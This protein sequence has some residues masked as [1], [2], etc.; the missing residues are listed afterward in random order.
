MLEVI[1]AL[2]VEFA[3][4]LA[5]NKPNAR[6]THSGPSA[7]WY[8]L[9][10]S[11]MR[12]LRVKV[13]GQLGQLKGLIPVC[14]K[15]CATSLSLCANLEPQIRH[16]NPEGDSVGTGSSST[17]PQIWQ[18]FP[19]TVTRNNS[20][21]LIPKKTDDQHTLCVAQ[22]RVQVPLDHGR[23]VVWNGAHLACVAADEYLA[24]GIGL[25]LLQ[26]LDG[27]GIEAMCLG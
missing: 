15:E 18:G 12:S 8:R 24:V 5:Q 20:T 13:R 2:L 1:L 26:L 10:W 6:M 19:V 22:G 14:A 25:F 4:I 23:V 7:R 27:Q 21:Q 16:W 11:R 3:R 17:P 9:M